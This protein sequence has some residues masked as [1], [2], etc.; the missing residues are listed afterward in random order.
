MLAF[1]FC[2]KENL[3]LLNEMVI[4]F[5]KGNILNPIFII[6]KFLRTFNGNLIYPYRMVD[7]FAI[8]LLLHQ[9]YTLSIGLNQCPI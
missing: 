6:Y 3:V 5:F 1:M 4:K 2:T 8:Y 7:I 9:F